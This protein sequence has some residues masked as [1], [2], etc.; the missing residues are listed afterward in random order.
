MNDYPL[1]I[2]KQ[3]MKQQK[4]IQKFQ[5]ADKLEKSGLTNK[6]ISILEDICYNEGVIVPG[7]S[8]PLILPKLYLKYKMNDKCWEYLNFIYDK[9]WIGYDKI[10]DLQAKI[11][12]SEGKNREALTMKIISLVWKYSNSKIKPELAQIEK[13]LKPYIN[14]ANLQ[15]RTN[16]IISLYLEF[17][18]KR[19]FNEGELR[20]LFEN[21]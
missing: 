17:V 14:K 1:S 18:N 12:K 9:G 3:L 8:W 2:K 10:R 7:E 5:E 4:Q 13:T 21:I 11:L 16:Q 6:A 20:Q 15:E 19:Q